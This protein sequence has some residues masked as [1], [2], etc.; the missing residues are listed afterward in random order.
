VSGNMSRKKNRSEDL[1]KERET[2]FNLNSMGAP[3]KCKL[4]LNVVL[5][6]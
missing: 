3:I 2:N 4:I 1:L 5:K 6:K